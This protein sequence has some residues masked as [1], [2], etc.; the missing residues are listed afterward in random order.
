MQWTPE[1][2][3]HYDFTKDVLDSSDWEELR[4]FEVLLRPFNKATKRAE[5]NATEGSHGALW[6]VIPTMNYLFIM[7]QM[8]ADDVTARPHIYT[9]HY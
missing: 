2:G 8:S 5:G 4:H 3:K 7:L 9:D 1:R 6:E